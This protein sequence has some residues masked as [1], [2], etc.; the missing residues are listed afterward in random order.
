MCM[1]HSL[2]I[3]NMFYNTLD[4]HKSKIHLSRVCVLSKL[5]KN[6]YDF[7]MIPSLL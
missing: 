4:E 1:Q 6:E 7:T 3:K 2:Q 5:H